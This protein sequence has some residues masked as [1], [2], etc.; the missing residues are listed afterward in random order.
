MMFNKLQ[1]N[2]TKS[3]HSQFIFEKQTAT[4]TKR[5]NYMLFEKP[6]FFENL[7][8]GGLVWAHWRLYQC[9]AIY[10]CP[11]IAIAI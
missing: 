6:V 2:L 9:M 3:A 10:I 8:T 11:Y 7:T 5:T 4:N 1:R